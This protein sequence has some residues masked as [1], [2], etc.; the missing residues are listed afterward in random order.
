MKA[1]E[2]LIE[3]AR[4]LLTQNYRQQPIVLTRGEGCR[5]WDVDGRSYLDMHAGLAVSILGHAHPRLTAAIAAQA[6]RLIHVSNL[7]FIEQQIRLAERLLGRTFAARVFFCNSGAEA[8]EAAIK[9]ARRHAHTVR[10]DKQ[11]VE[12]VACTNS[13]HGR[14]VATVS[15]T[16][17]EKYREGFGPLWEYVRFV[18]FGDLDAMA[19]A[20]GPRTFAVLVEPVQAEGGIVVPPDGYLAGLRRICDSAGALLILDEVQTGMGR[21][22]TFLAHQHES[23]AP[24]IATMAK[25]LA[26]GVPIGAMLCNEEAARGF[27][28]GT[29]ASTFGG[30]PLACAA[31]LAVFDVLDEERLIERGREAGTRLRAGLER[32]AARRPDLCAGVRGRGLLLGLELRG[33]ALGL[34]ERCRDRGLLV[35]VVGGTVIRFAPPLVAGRDEIDEALALLDAALG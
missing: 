1:G 32:V 25:G 27:S 7:F 8:N 13:F 19:R 21:T 34:V 10:G 20:V 18:P 12:L 6:G 11:R 26:G 22:G 3:A 2:T 24:D 9:L 5:V 31:A 4:R 14:T 33:E 30:N 28:P 15:A 29:H 23:M 35:S 16:G 17:Q